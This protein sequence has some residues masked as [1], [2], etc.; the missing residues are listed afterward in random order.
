MHEQADRNTCE[1]S[2]ERTLAEVTVW[3]PIT[4][5][6][7]ASILAHQRLCEVS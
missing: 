4:G 5:D 7:L 2:T 6:D 3:E 1:V